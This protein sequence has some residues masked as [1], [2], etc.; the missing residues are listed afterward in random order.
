MPTYNFKEDVQVFVVS[1]GNR[2]RIDVKDV[3]FGQT[4]TESSYPVKTLHA[5]SNV[6][7]GSVINKANPASFSF[8]A[9]G[10]VEADYTILE[11]LLIQ[12]TSFDLFIK[13]SADTFKLETAVITNGSFVIERS[14]PLSIQIQ[15]QAS[16]LTRNATLTG[17]LQARSSTSSYTLP[18]VDV[19]IGSTSLG[20]VVSAS[21]ELQ[22]QIT[23]TAHTTVNSALS[24]TNA[25]N[26]MYPQNF[27]LS[28]KILSGSIAQ[29]LTNENT[30]NLQ[31]W[32][33]DASLTIK[34]GN[35]LTGI[36]F[37]GFSMGPATCSF[38]NRVSTGSIFTQS[39]DWRLTENPSSLFSI[40]KYETD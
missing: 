13:T 6:F 38:T 18:V 3:T 17:T 26:S 5:Q 20:S 23:W 16:K 24:V 35:G 39:Y 25:S 31:N 21:M 11:T 30:S 28:K 4:F 32:D 1:G 34:A 27:T 2:H 36:N 22:N 7:E 8:E 33:T 29:Y 15:G 19:T 9:A 40:L 37:R 10:I 12:A 14:R